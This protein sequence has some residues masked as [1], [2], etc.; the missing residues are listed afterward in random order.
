MQC[1]F[2]KIKSNTQIIFVV[3]DCK[4]F[5]QWIK[6]PLSISI[7]EVATAGEMSFAVE[8]NF[9]SRVQSAYLLNL[10][11]CSE[12]RPKFSENKVDSEG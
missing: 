8:G 7:V 1:Y 10:L 11:Y 3:S 5:I 6:D 4:G 12:L 2:R 9:V